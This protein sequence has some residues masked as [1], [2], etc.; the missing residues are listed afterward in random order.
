[1][2]RAA[3]QPPVWVSLGGEALTALLAAPVVAKTAHFMLHRS[4]PRPVVLDL[5]TGDAP[6][7]PQSVDKTP[8]ALS[9]PFGLALVVPKRHAKRAVTR[10]L[11][12]RQMREAAR[13]HASTMTGGQWLVRLR[14]PF[15]PRQYPSAASA[16]LRAAVHGELEQLLARLGAPA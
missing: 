14:A 15:D 2:P 13:R 12:K 9:T 11:V 1:M 5:T 4:P 8:Q 3:P 6:D 10:N 7:R 16:P